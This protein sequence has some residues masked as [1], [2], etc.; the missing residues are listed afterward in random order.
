SPVGTPRPGSNC[1]SSF[2]TSTTLWMASC[3]SIARAR[4]GT[5]LRFRG[6]RGFARTRRLAHQPVGL[7]V[8][9][10]AV[11]ILAEHR[12]GL[13][14]FLGNPEREIAFDK[15]LQLLGRVAGGLILVDDRAEPQTCREPVARA[16]VE[17][18]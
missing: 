9:V 4:V 16:L 2:S 14:R 17:P 18:A 6:R 11:V 3:L 10:S 1:S 8:P 15:S 7:L 12:C 5:P 13:L